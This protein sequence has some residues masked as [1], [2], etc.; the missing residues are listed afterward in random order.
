[1]K[2]LLGAENSRGV[3]IQVVDTKRL[4]AAKGGPLGA[5][6]SAFVPQTIDSKV[7]SDIRDK[8]ASGLKEEGVDAR[9][10]VVVPENYSP[11]GSS[12]IWKPVAIGLGVGVAGFGVWKL[13]KYLRG[14]K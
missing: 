12:P 6:A 1:M 3:L 8:I 9:V 13:V 2:T 5:F 11:A 4:A 7:Y 14:R 10:T